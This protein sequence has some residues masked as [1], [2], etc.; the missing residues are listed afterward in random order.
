MNGR[1]EFEEQRYSPLQMQGMHIRKVLRALVRL[2]TTRHQPIGDR[3][4]WTAVAADLTAAI[5]GTVTIARVDAQCAWIGIKPDRAVLMRVVAKAAGERNGSTF[6]LMPGA[7]VGK[8]VDFKTEERATIADWLDMKRV[9]I[10]PV[11]AA[12]LRKQQNRAAQAAKRRRAG[13]AARDGAKSAQAENLGVHRST[14]WRRA[15]ATRT[16]AQPMEYSEA[17]NLTR[18]NA[19]RTSALP[20]KRN[21]KISAALLIGNDDA[22]VAP[23]AD[24]AIPP[25]PKKHAPV[26]SRRAK[27]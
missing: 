23:K 24:R 17:E 20:G 10:V 25:L 9:G 22:N 19:T 27:Q 18:V 16:S 14:L 15:N 8:L 4:G 3:A 5:Y 21:V 11:D 26:A 7:V 13:V 6:T 1:T 2:R 12:E